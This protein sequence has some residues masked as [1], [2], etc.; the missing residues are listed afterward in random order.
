MK[1]VARY[2]FVEK[3]NKEENNCGCMVK[4]VLTLADMFSA[5][6]MVQ[7]ANTMYMGV[8]TV[9][10]VTATNG[11]AANQPQIMYTAMPQYQTQ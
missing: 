11:A 2:D 9:Q 8:P 1:E 5:Y 6:R 4:N 10:S 7:P 3:E